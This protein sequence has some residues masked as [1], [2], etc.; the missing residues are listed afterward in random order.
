MTDN[1]FEPFE[2]TPELDEAEEKRRN[3]AKAQIKDADVE[4]VKEVLTRLPLRDSERHLVGQAARKICFALELARQEIAEKPELLPEWRAQTR[5]DARKPWAAAV[6]E[7]AA[8][9]FFILTGKAVTRVSKKVDRLDG[10][11]ETGE[12]ASFL[13]EVFGVLG[14]QASMAGQAKTWKS[15][16]PSAETKEWIHPAD[17]RTF[18]SSPEELQKLLHQLDSAMLHRL[19]S[20]DESEDR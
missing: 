14:I 1:P 6:T 18:L 5:P 3:A 13:A 15:R 17:L 4:L 8:D 16:Y 12:F 7:V 11:Q 10:L 20:A 2:T 9:W 19:G